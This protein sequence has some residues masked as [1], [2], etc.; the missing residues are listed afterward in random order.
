[1]LNVIVLSIII[2]QK[3]LLLAALSLCLYAISLCPYIDT[4]NVP[5]SMKY[6]TIDIVY[7]YIPIF[8]APN[9]LDK[10]GVVTNGNSIVNI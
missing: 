2:S 9:T 10:Y 1:M 5:N 6:V 3:A 7:P 4:P 8:S